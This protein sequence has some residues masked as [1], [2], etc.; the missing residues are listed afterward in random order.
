MHQYLFSIGSNTFAERNIKKV[1]QL[2]SREFPDIVFSGVYMSKPH[3]EKYKRLFLNMIARF[4]S[5]LPETEI[6][7]KAK[8][9]EQSMG[10]KPEDKEKGRVIID[11]D[12]ICKNEQILRL[13]DYERDYVQALLRDL[14]R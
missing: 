7:Q 10:R 14:S 6:V 11:I 3:G 8:K 4:P 9:I 13:R 2:L 1:K 12:L 5:N